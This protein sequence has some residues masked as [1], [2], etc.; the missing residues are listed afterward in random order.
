[1]FEGV[2]P[3]EGGALRRKSRRDRRSGLP[4]ET[5]LTFYPRIA[6]EMVTKARRYWS[7]FRS[8]QRILKE[9]LAA[10][11]RRNY[12]D[13][14]IAPAAPDELD[15]LDLYRVTHGGEAAVARKRRDDL[16]RAAAG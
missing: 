8:M 11:D 6:A 16:L 4:R 9:A 7:V 13:I 12:I 2:H 14:A 15:Y 10:P 1:M 5:P 3:L